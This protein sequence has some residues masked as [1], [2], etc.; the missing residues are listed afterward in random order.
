[1]KILVV[2]AYGVLGIC[3]T[4]FGQSP[5][6]SKFKEIE[7]A[8]YEQDPKGA[9]TITFYIHIDS[10]GVVN[11]LDKTGSAI[12]YCS[13]LSPD[14]TMEKLNGIFNGTS[15]IK[16]H[17]ISDKLAKGMHYAGDYFFVIVR[18]HD[19]KTDELTYI[20]PFMDDNFLG[21][22]DA[23]VT[24]YFAERNKSSGQPFHVSEN[25]ISKLRASH[26]KTKNLPEK[27]APPAGN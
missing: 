19:N 26:K 9:P 8:S 16:T 11:I 6:R 24:A 25:F 23:V 15:A 14:S 12:R 13:F 7:W 5:F 27:E 2:F 10:T 21:A 20:E 3:S 1:M 22:R 18:A 17:M 4:L